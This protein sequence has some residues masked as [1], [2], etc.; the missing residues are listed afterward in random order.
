MHAHGWLLIHADCARVY[1]ECDHDRLPSVSVHRKEDITLRILGLQL[2]DPRTRDRGWMG[3]TA[4]EALRVKRK[5][6]SAG[7]SQM[8]YTGAWLSAII[9]SVLD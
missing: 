7:I 8:R 1:S 9:F 2:D 4:D 6:K 3:N 5:M